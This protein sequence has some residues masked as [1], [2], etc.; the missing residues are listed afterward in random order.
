MKNTYSS[1]FKYVIY[2]D[3]KLDSVSQMDPF[4]HYKTD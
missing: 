1:P 2:L 4:G 3:I